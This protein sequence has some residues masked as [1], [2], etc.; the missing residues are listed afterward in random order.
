M[1]EATLA[2]NIFLSCHGESPYKAL[3]GRVPNILA[4]FEKAHGAAIE[5]GD[6]G[7]ISRSHHRLREISVQKIVEGVAQDRASRALR[8]KT[9]PA[10]QELRLGIG[11]EIDFW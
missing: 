11:D 10:L 6:P 2:K 1:A 8:L 7:D 3:Y 5:D 4:E 9:R